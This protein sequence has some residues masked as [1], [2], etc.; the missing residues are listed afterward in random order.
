MPNWHVWPVYSGRT[1]RVSFLSSPLPA[2][3]STKQSTNQ[4]L[5]YRMLQSSSNQN[6]VSN[7]WYTSIPRHNS[8]DSHATEITLCE[9]P[10]SYQYSV[11]KGVY[12]HLWSQE[13]NVSSHTLAHTVQNCT[14]HPNALRLLLINRHWPP[15]TILRNSSE[16]PST[17]HTICPNNLA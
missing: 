6:K 12:I 8:V 17:I 5:P 14:L 11:Y 7:T 13:C 4:I 16:Y 15:N 1:R 2:L 9:T 3:N 10:T